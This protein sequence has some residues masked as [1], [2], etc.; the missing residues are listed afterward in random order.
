MIRQNRLF[1]K[2]VIVGDADRQSPSPDGNDDAGTLR[3]L[4]LVSARLCHELSGPIA[5]INNGVELIAEEDSGFIGDA[6]AL[7]NDSARRARDRLQFYRFAYGFSDAAMGAG[8]APHELWR[9]FF[10]PSRIASDCAEN[11]W[12]LSPHWQKLACNLLAV[13]ADILPRGGHVTLAYGPL[14]LEAMGEAAALSEEASAAL[15]LRAPVSRLTARTV[16]AYFTG[17]LAKSLGCRIVATAEPGRVQITA[18]T[19][20]S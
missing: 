10:D 20:D 9:G 18:A 3:L 15:M 17:L 14:T 4:A 13:G 19:A 6:M 5:A 2:A 7:V 8:P 11:I 16:H 1:P 12:S